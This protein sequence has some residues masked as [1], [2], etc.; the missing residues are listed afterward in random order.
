MQKLE[1]KAEGSRR[2]KRMYKCPSGWCDARFY[3]DLDLAE[4]AP[5]CQ[6]NK[7][8]H[9]PFCEEKFKAAS[10]LIVRHVETNHAMERN[11]LLF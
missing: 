8:V 1:Q 7:A 6:G 11:N 4:H 5:V 3:T 9:C 2:K 10:Y